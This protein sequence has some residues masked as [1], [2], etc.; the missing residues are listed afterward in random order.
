MEAATQEERDDPTVISIHE[1]EE[2]TEIIATQIEA[3]AK[4]AE[5]ML[6]TGLTERGLIVLLQDTIGP[7]RITRTAIAEVLD[8]L[9]RLRRYLDS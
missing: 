4:A 1:G 5:K 6:S 9:P 2:S 7:A 8:A 3:I